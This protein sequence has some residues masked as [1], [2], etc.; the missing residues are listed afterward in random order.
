MK[1]N[2]FLA[3]F[4]CAALC[5]TL[6]S[7]VRAAQVV[8]YALY[9]DIVAE[10]DGHPIRSFNVGGN[11]AI[12]AEDLKQYGFY[13]LWQ[14][15]DVRTLHV[16]WN[17]EQNKNVNPTY[18]PEENTHPIGSRAR[19]ILATDIVTSVAGKEVESFNID[20]ETLIWFDDLAAFGNVVWDG[21][22][23]VISLTVGNP[24]EI[25]INRLI[26]NIEN[27]RG[28]TDGSAYTLYQ[29]E[30]GTIFYAYWSGLPHGNT[31]S[32]FMLIQPNGTQV[33]LLR[34]LSRQY[35]ERYPDRD[36]EGLFVTEPARMEFS[37]YGQLVDFSLQVYAPESELIGTARCSLDM[38]APYFFQC[39]ILDDSWSVSIPAEEL[40]EIP[41]GLN[42]AF[43]ATVIR[44]GDDVSVLSQEGRLGAARYVSIFSTGLSLGFY[45]NVGTF[46]W[47]EVFEALQAIELP[48]VWREDYSGNDNTPQQ[49]AAVS[50]WIE[51][52]GADGA[53][54]PGNAWWGK[55]NNHIDLYFDFDEPILLEDGDTVTV[56]VGNLPQR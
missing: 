15:G 43:S 53:V 32:Q 49:R 6:V 55:G 38:A 22:N 7:P 18:V 54:V 20:G 16:V 37:E 28:T 36:W 9:T 11:T 23:R 30:R 26:Q 8:D 5:L 41:E 10:I 12:V 44:R 17:N 42:T 51:V 47:G 39:G 13:A 19:A 3:A 4:F 34:L 35:A 46:E 52:I 27:F 2:R 33:D 45:A 1:R 48:A 40:G 29:N 31:Y 56:R 50:R 14:G 21:E 25:T 24:M